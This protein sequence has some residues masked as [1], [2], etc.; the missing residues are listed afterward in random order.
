VNLSLLPEPF[1]HRDVIV[2]FGLS[3]LVVYLCP[4]PS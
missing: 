1:Q 3:F 2:S 4:A